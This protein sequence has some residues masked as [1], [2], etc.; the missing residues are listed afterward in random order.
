MVIYQQ[1]HQRSVTSWTIHSLTVKAALQIGLH[2][3][4]AIDD[5]G[6]EESALSRRLWFAVFNNDRLARRFRSAHTESD[7]SLGCFP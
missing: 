5:V 6:Q 3:P 1:N 7:N 2:S 4:V